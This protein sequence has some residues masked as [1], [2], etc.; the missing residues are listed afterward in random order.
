MGEFLHK[1]VTEIKITIYLEIQ[2][3]LILSKK[4]KKK[5]EK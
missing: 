2:R 4:L 3:R 5:K 1:I